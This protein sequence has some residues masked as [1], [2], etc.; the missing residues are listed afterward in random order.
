MSEGHTR[1]QILGFC[2][3]LNTGD[4][5]VG[6]TWS[7]L[8]S[9]GIGLFLKLSSSALQQVLFGEN[10]SRYVHVR[11]VVGINSSLMKAM[12]LVVGKPGLSFPKVAILMGGPGAYY[13]I[14]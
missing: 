11:Q 7:V 8:Y 10:L 13:M 1:C 5:F 6:W 2:C 12:R 4:P 14:Q 3:R 9:S